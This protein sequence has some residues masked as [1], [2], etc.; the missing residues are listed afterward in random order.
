MTT[1]PENN[2]SNTALI[3]TAATGLVFATFAGPIGALIGS[4]LGAGLGFWHDKR[5]LNKKAII[6]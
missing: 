6:K 1:H 3:A 4:V 5:E 2:S